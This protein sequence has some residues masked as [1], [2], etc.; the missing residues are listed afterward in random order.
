M[1][2][3]IGISADSALT[4][5]LGEPL[6]SVPCKYQAADTVG[7]IVYAAG[8]VT[9]R[10]CGSSGL[11]SPRQKARL[12]QSPLKTVSVQ[13]KACRHVATPSKPYLSR[14]AA[15]V[16]ARE[17]MPISPNDSHYPKDL[18]KAALL[19]SVAQRLEVS[20]TSSWQD[21]HPGA[22]QFYFELPICKSYLMMLR[23]FLDR[24]IRSKSDLKARQI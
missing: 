7:L 3:L 4:A 6:L 24:N 20:H 9:Q 5:A 8:S 1:S 21:L 23:S 18:R 16:E 19:R 22:G 13:S 11:K 2:Q 15:A 10:S 12:R 17:T 14:L